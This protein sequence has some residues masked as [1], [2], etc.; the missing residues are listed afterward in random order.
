MAARRRKEREVKKTTRD[1]VIYWSGAAA[2]LAGFGALALMGWRPAALAMLAAVYAW[3][4]LATLLGFNP[5]MERKKRS[6]AY[7]RSMALLDLMCAAALA[8]APLL[9]SAGA[10]LPLVIWL[11][12]MWLVERREKQRATKD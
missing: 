8:A 6:R 2:V 5:H 1:N 3:I 9:F 12:G 11:A 7:W 4:G 10:L